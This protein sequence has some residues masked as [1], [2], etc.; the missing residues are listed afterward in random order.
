MTETLISQLF[1]FGA[2]GI[3]AGFLI[4][5]HLGMQRRLDALVTNFQQQLKE[6]DD[7]F[8]ARIEKMRERY[9]VVITGLR[10]EASSLQKDVATP[11]SENSKILQD[12]TTKFDEGLRDMRDH[13]AALEVERKL[14]A[15]LTK[16]CLKKGEGKD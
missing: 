14:R 15:E 4:W 6:I 9:D 8:D 1:D 3:F 5:Q 2:L 10:D 11:L 16:I 12:L 7:S 13:Y